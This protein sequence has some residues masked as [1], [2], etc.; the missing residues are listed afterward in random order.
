MTSDDSQLTPD[1]DSQMSGDEHPDR[2]SDGTAS[3]PETSAGLQA[4][5]SHPAADGFSETEPTV[6]SKRRSS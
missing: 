6:I 5:N 2:H 3:V 4:D 1:E